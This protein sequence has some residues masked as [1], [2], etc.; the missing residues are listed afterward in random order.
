MAFL[1]RAA[2]A[3]AL[4][5]AA[6]ASAQTLTPFENPQPPPPPAKKPPPRKL[7]EKK[8]PEKPGE[9]RHP[10]VRKH[11]PVVAAGHRGAPVRHPLRPTSAKP[12]LKPPAAKPPEA[13]AAKPPPPAPRKP[14]VPADVGTDTGLHLPRFA[15]LKTDEVNMRAGPGEQY[16]VLWQYQRRDLPIKIE[17]E[18][19]KWRLVE[20]M[21]GIKGWMHEATLTSHRDFVVNGTA[22]VALRAQASDTAEA[23]AILK[24]GVIGRLRACDAR[25]AWC[26]VQVQSYQGFVRRS[27]I[28]G[29]LEGEAITP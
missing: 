14:P 12:T 17:R 15:S 26:E 22:D 10:A 21:D 3:L 18:F 27:D 9:H 1:F 29:L 16:P 19:D 11:V 13:Q 24:P 25:G 5:L 23:V 20:D 7:T 2:L 6:P 4:G 8:L 28:W